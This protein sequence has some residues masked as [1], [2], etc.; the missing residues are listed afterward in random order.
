MTQGEEQEPHDRPTTVL[1]SGATGGLGIHVV[2]ILVQSG[3]HVRA[4]DRRACEEVHRTS[5]LD[6]MESVDWHY[7]VAEDNALRKLLTG[8][9]AVVHCA[10]VTS[11]SAPTFRLRQ[12]NCELS[13]KLFQL[14]TDAGVEHFVHISC[15]TVYRADSGVCTEESA[16]EAYNAFEESKLAAEETLS[17]LAESLEDAPS[18]TILRP[19][20][21]YG[22]GCTTMGAGMIPLPAI[23]RGISRYLPALSGGPRTN[24]CHVG[25]AARAVEVVL[26]HRD[27]RDQIFNVADENALSF[28]EVLTSIIEG[29]GIDLGPSVRMPT[30][31]LWTLLGPLLDKDWAFEQMRSVLQFLWRRV[32]SAHGIDSPLSPRLNRDALFY[33]RDDAIVVADKLR[34]LGWA[35]QWPDFR[36]GIA[37]TIRWY[38]RQGWAPRFSLDAMAERRSTSLDSDRF[39]FGERLHGVLRREKSKPSQPPVDLDFEILWPTFPWPRSKTEGHLNGTVT[40]PEIATASPVKGTVRVHW[41][42]TP[43]IRYQFG[44]R[45]NDDDACRFLGT[46]QFAPS[47]P[48]DS[49]LSLRGHIVDSR[50]QPIG[51]LIARSTNGVL[52]LLTSSPLSDR[53]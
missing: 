18:L 8:C 49:L 21:L 44:F 36:R 9:E 53:S 52:P 41:F 33:L 34:A 50:G 12:L 45:D 15:A 29:Y 48:L 30:L 28:G 4:I 19:G 2:R 16:T 6:D 35:P 24:W 43:S 39:R 10:G 37:A 27:A 46:R 51:E 13:R 14:S 17:K 26:G 20:L 1:V 25:D 5:L 47:A 40:I 38:Q 32:Q 22:P 11:L 42:P 23:L 31:T 3:Y 7:E